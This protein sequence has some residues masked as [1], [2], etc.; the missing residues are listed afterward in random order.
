MW[1]KKICVAT[2]IIMDNDK[3]YDNVT[4]RFGWMNS[5]NEEIVYMTNNNLLTALIDRHTF[6]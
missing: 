5:L 6:Y 2:S 1:V 4:F 3:K